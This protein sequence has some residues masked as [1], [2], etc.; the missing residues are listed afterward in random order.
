MSDQSRPPEPA[1]FI[2]QCRREIDAAWLYVEAAREVLRRSRWL[3]AV[4]AERSRLLEAREDARLS[5]AGRSEAAR[6]GMFVGVVDDSRGGGR[7]IRVPAP[8]SETGKSRPRPRPA[9]A[10]ARS[11]RA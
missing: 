4:W 5:G 6:I 8:A 10:A 2:A 9:A 7:T 1:A 3:L 11:P